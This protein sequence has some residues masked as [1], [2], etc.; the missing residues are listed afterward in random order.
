MHIKR[1]LKSQFSSGMNTWGHKLC[2]LHSNVYLH[3]LST[4][5]YQAGM[6]AVSHHF[7][8]RDRLL[9]IPSGRIQVSNIPDPERSFKAILNCLNYI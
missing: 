7:Q 9:V 5:R 3:E 2:L 4:K 8:E 1:P 6:P